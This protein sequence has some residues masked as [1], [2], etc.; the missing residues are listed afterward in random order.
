MARQDIHLCFTGG[1]PL[2]KR[3]QVAVT[4]IMSALRTYGR[5]P[6]NITFETNGTQPLSEDFVEH[7]DKGGLFSGNLFW[8]FSP[9]LFNV[10][11]VKREK[12]ITPTDL[13]TYRMM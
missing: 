12:E 10:S 9:K 6:N 7:F 3:S 13:Q 4:E 8:S 2:M 5:M 1:E 11:G